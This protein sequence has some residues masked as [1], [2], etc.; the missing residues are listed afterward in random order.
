M[1]DIRKEVE[2][3]LSVLC[4]LELSGVN[5]ATDMLTLSFGP[6]RQVTN[7]KGVAKSVGAWALHVQCAW[8]LEEAGHAVATEADL[9]G[10]DEKAHASARCLQG[11]LLA[12]GFSAVEAVTAHEA[13]GLDLLLSHGFL[14][15]VVPDGVAGE[16]DWRFFV[17]GSNAEHFVISGGKVD[18]G[19]I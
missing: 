10:P 17:P 13:G 8:R 15:T 5:H 18:P 2:K 6:L 14:L 16:E 3:R 1:I 11:I 7:F 19:G 12:R 9:R 4:G